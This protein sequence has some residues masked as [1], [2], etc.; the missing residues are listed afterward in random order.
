MLLAEKLS[1]ILEALDKLKATS[2]T[3]YDVAVS[4]IDKVPNEWINVSAELNRFYN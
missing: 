3:R 1:F 4:M 2:N